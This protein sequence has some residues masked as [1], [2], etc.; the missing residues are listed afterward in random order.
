MPAGKFRGGWFLCFSN[1]GDLG[2]YYFRGQWIL[3]GW[4]AIDDKIITIKNG[5]I[6]VGQSTLP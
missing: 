1:T 3:D 6:Y 4:I 2:G 5:E